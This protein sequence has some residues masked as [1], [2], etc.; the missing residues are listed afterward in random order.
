MAIG[1]GAAILGAAVLGTGGG[2]L[3][4]NKQAGAL[5][6][7]QKGQGDIQQQMLD[8]Q[9][10]VYAE[11]KPFREAFGRLL[12]SLE[13][14]AGAP[15]ADSQ[16]TDEV[17][18]AEAEFAKTG[19]LRSGAFQ[20]TIARAIERSQ[21]RQ[22]S[23]GVQA[24]ALASGQGNFATQQAQGL[25]GPIANVQGNISQLQAGQ[26]A[27]QGGLFSSIG[28]QLGSLGTLYGLG[29]FDKGGLFGSGNS[30]NAVTSGSP[31]VGFGKPGSDLKIL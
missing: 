23:R 27:V 26:G 10:E 28:N 7:A 17:R 6:K 18:L 2:L 14:Q 8:F 15:I 9:R 11:G 4:A 30:G 1:T 31:Y 12:T 5:K 19:N 13:D 20:D 21:S 29:A 24:A 22:F 3:A 16:L 25:F